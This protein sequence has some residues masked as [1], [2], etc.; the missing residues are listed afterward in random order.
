M[1][2]RA[3]ALG[4]DAREIVAVEQ[5]PPAH[6]LDEPGDRRAA[7]SSCPP[8]LRPSSAT[9]SPATTRQVEVADHGGLVVA[10][11][12]ALDREHGAQRIARPRP[13][14]AQ[15][16]APRCRGRRADH[17]CGRARTDVGRAARDHLA[18]LEHDDLVADPEH[19][20]HVVVDEQHRLAAVG[21]ARAGA[22]PSSSLSCV[23]RPAAGSS[24][25]TS[26]GFATSARAIPTSLRCPCESS[27]GSRV[28]DR[29]EPEQLQRRVDLRR[30][31]RSGGETVSRIVRQT[32]GRCEATSR[33]SRT[34]RSS[35]SSIDCHVRASPRRARACGGSPVRSCPSS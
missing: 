30:V 33:F 32:D 6:R 3:R 7:S 24:R 35:N 4:D 19:E 16:G 23:S 10:G 18:E 1:P 2:S 22:G 31:P 12:Q 28:G 29:L 34:V 8:R 11:G 9:T 15:L 20:A 5:D 13:R 21:E 27:L 25:Q 17:A 26:R 14:P